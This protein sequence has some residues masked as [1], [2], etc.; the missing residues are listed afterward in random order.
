MLYRTLHNF[1]EIFVPLF[2]FGILPGPRP[3]A[4]LFLRQNLR[5]IPNKTSALDNNWLRV[6]GNHPMAAQNW[7]HNLAQRAI[8]WV[9]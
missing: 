4:L 9:R 8:G 6:S 1:I 7:N 3:Q 2:I 5:Q